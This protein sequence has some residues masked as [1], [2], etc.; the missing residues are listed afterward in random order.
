[1]KFKLT[2]ASGDVLHYPLSEFRISNEESRVVGKVPPQWTESSCDIEFDTLEELMGFVQFFDKRGKTEII[3]GLRGD[4][5]P[6]MMIYD[7]Y[8][9]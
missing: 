7:D 5:E 6:D 8:I 9:E 4:N 1:M 3:V 2:A